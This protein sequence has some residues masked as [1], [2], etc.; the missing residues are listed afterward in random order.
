[1][2]CL[3]SD[4]KKWGMRI[5]WRSVLLLNFSFNHPFDMGFVMCA[6]I[7]RTSSI[8]FIDS[9]TLTNSEQSFSLSRISIIW[10]FSNML[11]W[12]FLFLLL[13]DIFYLFTYFLFRSVFNQFI[14]TSS[15][16]PPMSANNN[17]KDFAFLNFRR[18]RLQL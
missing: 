8:L 10:K 4:N 11:W 13:V 6:T 7:K 1:M 15:C 14:F 5:G 16:S 18:S 2:L 9:S 12:L 3:R 17:F